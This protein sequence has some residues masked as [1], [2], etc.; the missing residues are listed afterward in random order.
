ME[1]LSNN[2]ANRVKSFELL[3]NEYLITAGTRKIFEI[4]FK[5]IELWDIEQ[6][7]KKKINFLP[8]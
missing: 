7:F 6:N 4:P 8:S 5:N 3:L 1:N 2:N